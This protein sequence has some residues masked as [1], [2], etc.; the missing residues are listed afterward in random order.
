MPGMSTAAVYLTMT[1]TGSDAVSV[2]GVQTPVAETAMLHE[3]VMENQMMRMKHLH[4]LELAPGETV[5]FAPGGKHIMLTG[6]SSHLEQGQSLEVTFS[7]A[8]GS[9]QTISA[10][11]GGMGEMHGAH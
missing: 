1:N 9:T 8:D 11:I 3:T 10:H 4:K 7:Y 6:V 5:T 2:T